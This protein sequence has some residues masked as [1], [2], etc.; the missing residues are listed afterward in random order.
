LF[1]P[2]LNTVNF[3][4]TLGVDGIAPYGASGPSFCGRPFTKLS[5]EA[6]TYPFAGFL[7]THNGSRKCNLKNVCHVSMHL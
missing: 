7:I 3:V 2:I 4:R 1:K 5:Q 6:L